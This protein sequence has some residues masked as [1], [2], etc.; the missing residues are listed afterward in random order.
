MSTCKTPDDC[1]EIFIGNCIDC[2]FSDWITPATWVGPWVGFDGTGDPDPLEGLTPVY[3]VELREGTPEGDSTV[4]H[5]ASSIDKAL[6]WA[7]DN[8]DD[9]LMPPEGTISIGDMFAIYQE[10]VDDPTDNGAGC[11][12][13]AWVDYKGQI[14]P[15]V[16]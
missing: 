12:F 2:P 3:V 10:Y 14:F 13:I 11:E 6:I 15:E 9:F 4:V 7:V 8:A 16:E 1:V 5:I